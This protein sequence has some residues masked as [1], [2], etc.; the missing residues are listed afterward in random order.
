MPFGCAVDVV[1]R[2]LVLWFATMQDVTASC[3]VQYATPVTIGRT[4]VRD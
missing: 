3:R 1:R 4:E 2:W